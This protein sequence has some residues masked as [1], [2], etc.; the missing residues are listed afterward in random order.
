[1]LL[2]GRQHAVGLTRHHRRRSHGRSCKHRLC[3]KGGQGS[4]SNARPGTANM[5]QLW[6]AADGWRAPDARLL[7]GYIL[8]L[9]KQAEKAQRSPAAPT[10][11]VRVVATPVAAATATVAATIR[12]QQV[13]KGQQGASAGASGARPGWQSQRARLSAHPLPGCSP[14]HEQRLAGILT[15]RR[16]SHGHSCK[17]GAEGGDVQG[18]RSAGSPGCSA[19]C[20]A[21]K[22][23]P[24]TTAVFVLHAH[25]QAN[26]TRVCCL[27]RRRRHSHRHRSRRRCTT[28]EKWGCV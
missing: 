3:D 21:G 18:N 12:R 8:L 20:S 28:Q 25:A 22:A 13:W 15:R 11:A 27:T 16:H 14:N 5:A 9:F 26:R 7:G 23:A 19:G 6:R 17:V 2:R 4:A 1:M 10:A 24:Q